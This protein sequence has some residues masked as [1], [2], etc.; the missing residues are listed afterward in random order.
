MY[1]LSKW[2]CATAVGNLWIVWI[3]STRRSIFTYLISWLSNRLSRFP[4]KY[5]LRG[6]SPAEETVSAPCRKK[7]HISQVLRNSR[8]FRI[9]KMAPRCR[10]FFYNLEHSR[11][12]LTKWELEFRRHATVTIALPRKTRLRYPKP[13]GS[14]IV[15]VRA[16]RPFATSWTW[17]L[18]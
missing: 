15:V 7:T 3:V 4:F 14:K 10:T 2:A 13:D 17:H 5:L 16:D 6:E 18:A 1:L 8:E 9:K 12:V 11:E